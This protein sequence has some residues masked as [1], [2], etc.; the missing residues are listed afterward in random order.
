MAPGVTVPL[1][2]THTHS[3]E[4]WS[5]KW[6]RCLLIHLI[7]GGP[8]WQPRV[9]LCLLKHPPW[10]RLPRPTRRLPWQQGADSLSGLG[11]GL[12]GFI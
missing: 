8:G 3:V 12:N 5:M 7:L 4:S 9:A 11:L 10:F 6:E 2:A 1:V